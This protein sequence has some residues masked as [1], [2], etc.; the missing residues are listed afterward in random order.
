MLM[1]IASGGATNFRDDSVAGLTATIPSKRRDPSN[2][3][4][5]MS[6][7]IEGLPVPARFGRAKSLKRIGEGLAAMRKQGS[8]PDVVLLQ[9]A[10]A[11]PAKDIAAEGGYRYVA[12]G[13]STSNL[14]GTPA[15]AEADRFVS[16]ASHWK[17]EDDG[18]WV[19]SGLRILSDYRIVRVERLA[20][21][22]WACA[23]Y[24]C[25]ANKGALIAWIQIPGS[26]RPIAFVDTHLNSRAA[27]GVAKARADAAYLFQLAE[28]RKF[29]AS[30]IPRNVAAF[31]GGD[32]NSGKAHVRQTALASPLLLDSRNSLSDAFRT[33]G[34][35]ALQ[36]RAD[37]ETIRRRGKDWLY[38]R[39]EVSLPVTLTG[40]EVPF[41]R[42]TDGSALSDHLG[43]EA[44]YRVGKGSARSA[45]A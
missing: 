37:I 24:D 23:G 8:Q 30:Q 16:A 27:S 3:L 25:L 43:Y 26:P 11:A 6:Y 18:K 10:F 1:L 32:F 31:L 7:N 17:G 45:G 39:G 41:G 21:P 28:L 44:T 2:T 15:P 40:Y 36:D 34:T 35:V 33:S 5:V 38:Y 42:L 19:D 13:P 29:I 22:A 12:D 20:F 9:E 4:T 14:N